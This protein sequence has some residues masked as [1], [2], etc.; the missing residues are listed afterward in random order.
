M[1]KCKYLKLPGNHFTLNKSDNN[2][3]DAVY[4][5]GVWRDKLGIYPYRCNDCRH[6]SPSNIIMPEIPLLFYYR[7]FR[8]P[9]KYTRA[10]DSNQTLG[11]YH[12]KGKTNAR[13]TMHDEYSKSIIDF[14]KQKPDAIEY[15]TKQ[16][17]DILN[18]NEEYVIC[19]IPSSKKG[20]ADS[21]IRTVAKR[22]CQLPIIDGTDVIIRNRTM[23]P[24][25]T[26]KQ[27]RSFEQELD[28]ITVVK[29]EIIKGK[30]V[31][32]LDD[33]ATRGYS[34]NAGRQ[35]LKEAGAI[36][37]AAIAIGHTQF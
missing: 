17:S 27:R 7:I 2:R 4:G 16:L 30:Q 3:G 37:V 34:L 20:L 13:N 5:C 29:E 14:K 33:V 21:G 36:L 1:Y 8:E 32:L 23:E 19:V 25:H 9:E 15:F 28:S 22:L 31:L 12:I 10:L 26:S 24:N 35:K 6:Y 18:D 11:K